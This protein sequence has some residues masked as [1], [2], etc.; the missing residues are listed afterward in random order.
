M[1]SALEQN[2]GAAELQ[3]FV[4]FLVD[5][6]E[7]QNVAILGPER[8]VERAEGAILRAEIRVVDVAVDLIGYNTW[9]VFLE[10]H[11]V[12]GHSDAYEVI[13]FKHLQGF[14]FG[15]S[16][17]YSFSTFASI[18]ADAVRNIEPYDLAVTAFISTHSIGFAFGISP[19][20][21]A[22]R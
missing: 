16:H 17:K 12:R 13:G 9:V 7:G 14:L 5:L 4:D 18:L 11:L 8:A 21:A 1:Q 15:Q 2:S 6:L 20:L 22:C 19:S 3:H 10:A